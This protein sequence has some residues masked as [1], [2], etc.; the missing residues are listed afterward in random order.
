MVDIT[1]LCTKITGPNSTVYMEKDVVIVGR[2][3]RL[4]VDVPVDDGS[5]CVSR[6]HLEIFRKHKQLYL[7]CF[8]KNGIFINGDF[9]MKKPEYVPLLDGSKLRFPSTNT[10]LF[11]EISERQ[12]TLRNPK[13]SALSF[14]SDFNPMSN[15]DSG[16]VQSNTS[17]RFPSNLVEAQQ[18][19]VL[20]RP[21]SS[22]LL[23]D[24]SKPIADQFSFSEDRVDSVPKPTSPIDSKNQK[25]PLHLQEPAFGEMGSCLKDSNSMMHVHISAAAVPQNSIL[26]S[27]LNSPAY[28]ESLDQSCDMDPTVLPRTHSNESRLSESVRPTNG[29]QKVW[30]CEI[31]RLAAHLALT[32]QIDH[33][34][35][36]RKPPYSYAQLIIQSI[37]SAFKQRLTLAGIYSHICSNFPYYRPSEKGWQNSIRHNLSLNRYFIRVPRS[38]VEPGKG[39]FWQLEPTCDARLITQAFKRRRQFEGSIT[40]QS[41]RMQLKMLPRRQ[42]TPI[43]HEEP[44]GLELADMIGTKGDMVSICRFT[45]DN[46]QSTKFNSLGYTFPE[47]GQSPSNSPFVDSTSWP[48]THTNISHVKPFVTNQQTG[49]CSI[50][51]FQPR[52]LSSR[53]LNNTILFQDRETARLLDERVEPPSAGW[54]TGHERLQSTTVR[55]S[56]TT[57]W[58]TSPHQC[59]LLTRFQRA[60]HS[61]NISTLKTLLEARLLDQL[62]KTTT[63]TIRKPV[64]CDESNSVSSPD[65]KNNTCGIRTVSTHPIHGSTGPDRDI[66]TTMT[67]ML[68]E[69]MLPLAAKYPRLSIPTQTVPDFWWSSV[70]NAKSMHKSGYGDKHGTMQMELHHLV[71]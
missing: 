63:T 17:E 43:I 32:A 40:E 44:V 58:P 22:T 35:A 51:T 11:V 26:F 30:R 2:K 21:L 46:C 14:H 24:S 8:S 49:E 19:E 33:G 42:A 5:E 7:K 13:K 64:C 16:I 37:A 68:G 20:Q 57:S 9:Y 65:E 62:S 12:E 4:F 3:S 69:M 67:Q 45:Q 52:L 54:S 6:K 47:A 34:S 28:E 36:V 29:T 50:R 1:L 39:A 38:T 15:S 23:R 70:K 66:Q 56:S 60:D 53:N 31:D 27:R 18:F 71:Q 48:T 25:L 55:S 41:T 61:L 59:D 10:I